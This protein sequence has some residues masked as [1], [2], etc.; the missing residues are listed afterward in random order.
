[1]FTSAWL[2]RN[3]YSVGLLKERPSF[4]LPVVNGHTLCLRLL[5]EMADNPEAVDVRDAKGQTPLMLAV[6]YGHIDAVSLL[7]EKEANVDAVDIVGCTAL[8]RGIMTGHEECVQLLLEQ[9]ACVL[10]RDARG[11]TPLHYAAARGHATWLS[12]LLQIAQSEEDCCLKD[13]QG[14]TPLHWACYNGNENCIEVLLEQKCFRKFVGNPFTPLHCAIINGHENCASLLLGAIDPSIVSC[15]D[16]KGRTTLHAAAFGDHA[17]CLQLLLRHGAQVNAVDHSGKTALMMAAENGQAGAVDIL[18]N[19]AQADLSGKDKDLNTPLHLA[20][21]KGHEGCALLI[22]DKI[23]DE[24]LINAKNSALQTP[25]HIAAR[26]GLTAVVEELL[27]KG[28]CVLVVDEN[29]HTPALACAP[30]KGVADC[31]ALILATMMPLSPS[32]AMT[33]VNLVGLRKDNW[34]R[35]TLSNLGSGVSLSSNHVGSEDGYN[36]NDSDSET[37]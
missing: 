18:V 28:A 8:H 31:L 9:D 36:E 24:S 27:A 33:A 17:E 19:G 34:S 25:L 14:Y 22:L 37:F 4:S 23:Q 1:M 29:G 6:A 32:S 26:N 13:N 5:L 2:W 7:L 3:S 15:R 10:C 16:D 12:E 21:S 30:N 35:T 20:I 11:R